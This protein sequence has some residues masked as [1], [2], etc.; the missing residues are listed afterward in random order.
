MNKRAISPLIATVL[1]VG[2]VFVLALVL[3]T[4]YKET[5]ETNTDE[6]D[7]KIDVVNLCLYGTDF[8]FDT[9][10]KYVD[11]L[12]VKIKNNKNGNISAFNFQ[13]INHDGSSSSIRI[14]KSM[15]GVSST[16]F[17]FNFS[18]DVSD[19]NKI[20][21]TPI[22]I[23]E[24]GYGE[25]TVKELIITSEIGLCCFDMDS[26]G[27][28]V[29][30]PSEGGDN[31]QLDC[32]DSNDETYPDALSPFTPGVPCDYDHD[33]DGS[34]GINESIYCYLDCPERINDGR[35]CWCSPFGHQDTENSYFFGLPI[36][37][38]IYKYCCDNT[39]SENA[40][41]YVPPEYEEGGGES[42]GELPQ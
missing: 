31:L 24:Q 12:S 42:E 6:T 8:E 14:N 10:C 28:D 32:D 34:F 9:P 30:T 5:V 22:I 38:N 33:C 39:P 29:C 1:L 3:M 25:C 13:V 18:G 16:R 23:T 35:P 4:F 17:N 11:D 26:D 41:N 27:F 20:L 7:K 40:C 19:V 21:I 36:I 37:P 2:F 15:A